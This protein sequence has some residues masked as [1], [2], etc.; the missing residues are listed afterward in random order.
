MKKIKL[1]EHILTN[2]VNKVISERQQ[3]KEQNSAFN[4]EHSSDGWDKQRD[5]REKGKYC[6]KSY[7]PDGEPS[8]YEGQHCV[9]ETNWYDWESS[10]GVKTRGM[11][12]HGK[13][14]CGVGCI[15]LKGERG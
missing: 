4:W 8:H 5:A 14:K 6:D 10:P 15:V 7:R 12:S 3:L 11:S 9:S 1:S 13:W 2:L